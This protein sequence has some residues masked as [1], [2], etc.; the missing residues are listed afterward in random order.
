MQSAILPP[1][2]LI[3]S[4]AKGDSDAVTA[5]LEA[6]GD[7]DSTI[8]GKPTALCY[9]AIGDNPNLAIKLIDAGASLNHQDSIG[10]TPIFYSMMA[11]SDLV[12]SLLLLCGANPLKTNKQGQCCRCYAKR[13][14][15]KYELLTKIL[16]AAVVHNSHAPKNLG[17]GLLH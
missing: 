6:G 4:A 3:I 7:P 17:L 1:Q 15:S 9:A 5:H 10:N 8:E 16:D 11:E 12:L 2:Q 14:S 13:S